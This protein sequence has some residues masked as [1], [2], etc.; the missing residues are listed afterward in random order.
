MATNFELYDICVKTLAAFNAATTEEDYDPIRHEIISANEACISVIHK[1]FAALD[2]ERR[3]SL[4][5]VL[6]EFA[7]LYGYIRGDWRDYKDHNRCPELTIQ[8][9]I[10]NVFIHDEDITVEEAYTGNDGYDVVLVTTALLR[11]M[12]KNFARKKMSKIRRKHFNYC[13]KQ[14]ESKDEFNTKP[15]KNGFMTN[16]E[17]YMSIIHNYFN[18]Y[19]L[20][21]DSRKNLKKVLFKYAKWY[22][23]PSKNESYSDLTIDDY[24]DDVFLRDEVLSVT[25]AYGNCGSYHMDL[26][27]VALLRE[28]LIALK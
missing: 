12:L 23:E 10:N 8:D 4:K 11:E 9:Y 28:M 6:F 24:I 2:S 26:G 25:E 16:H 1:H 7:G 13:V 15:N 3:N 17:A 21:E 19:E 14:L 18:T 27:T 22:W 5:N 20:D